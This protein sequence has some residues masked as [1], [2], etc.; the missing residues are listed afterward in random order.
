MSVMT[1]RAICNHSNFW[2]LSVV[3]SKFV[4]EV[5]ENTSGLNYYNLYSTTIINTGIWYHVAVTRSGSTITLYV[6]GIAESS[7]TPTNITNLN[8]TAY[9]HLGEGPC[10]SFIGHMDET[11]IWNRALSS[12]E[13]NANRNCEI[14]TSYNGLLAN[15]H[16]NQ[17]T[18]AGNNNLVNTLLDASGNNNTAYLTE[19]TLSGVN[20]NWVSDGAVISGQSC[21]NKTSFS[22][23]AY[24][25]NQNNGNVLVYDLNTNTE[26]AKVFIGNGGY[27]V[28]CTPSGES[29]YVSN[30][31]TNKVCV[32]DAFT[33][34]LKAQIPVGTFPFGICMKPDGSRLYSINSGSNSVSVINTANNTVTTSITVSGTPFYG[35][36]SPNGQFLYVGKSSWKIRL[37]LLTLSQIP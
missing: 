19:F 7:I 31:S 37:Q 3:A 2:S 24:I 17:G 14:A 10:S 33:N 32:I 25:S 20:S 4:F 18:A 27:G 1:K 22:P 34:T 11:R 13:I 36:C 8:N 16:Y 5:D 9:L 6:N 29:V 35:A 26:K 28:T 30:V 21:T 12:C 15:Y 23:R